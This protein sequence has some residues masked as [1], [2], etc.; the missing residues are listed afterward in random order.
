[1]RVV[2][3][4]LRMINPDMSKGSAAMERSDTTTGSEQ[5]LAGLW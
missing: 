4:T 5:G 2:R 3:R 1:M